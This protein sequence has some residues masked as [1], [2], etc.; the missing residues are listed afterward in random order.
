MMHVDQTKLKEAM[1]R[2]EASQGFALPIRMHL[3]AEA[4]IAMC[5]N[6]AATS[7]AVTKLAAMMHEELSR[8][9]Q[10]VESVTTT[11]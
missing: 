11:T 10:M 6:Q 9:R 8:L 3:M 1:R 7:N 2:L 5:E 4:T